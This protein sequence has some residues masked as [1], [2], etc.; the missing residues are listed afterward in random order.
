LINCDL[1]FFI[2]VKYCSFFFSDL[3]FLVMPNTVV[4]VIYQGIGDERGWRGERGVQ[5]EDGVDEEEPEETDGGGGGER[6][7]K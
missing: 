5:G 3:F 4:C 2:V 6:A 1:F 7:G